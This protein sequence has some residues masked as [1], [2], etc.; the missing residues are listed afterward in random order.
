MQ[1]H[2][3]AQNRVEKGHT[4]LCFSGAD[5]AGRRCVCACVWMERWRDRL[6]AEEEIE[7]K[8]E[9]EGDREKE[10]VGGSAA[11]LEEGCLM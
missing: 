6:P 8:R 7:R 5:R 2:T 4:G 10:E 3:S 9:A 11:L 1:T